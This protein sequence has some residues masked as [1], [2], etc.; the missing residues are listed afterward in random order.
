MTARQM[1][2]LLLL[3][4]VGTACH[5]AGPETG[6]APSAAIE[7]ITWNLTELNGKPAAKGADGKPATLILS[8]AGTRANGYAG[9]NRF[10]GSYTLAGSELKFGLLGMTKMACAGSDE[11]EHGYTKALAATTEHRLVKG[12]LQ[13]YA[14]D[15]LV[16]KFAK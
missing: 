11:L 8:A 15:V 5:Q 2:A 13:L 4:A 1:L 14:G 6:V 3:T 12:K 9:C 7:G 16:A 10:F